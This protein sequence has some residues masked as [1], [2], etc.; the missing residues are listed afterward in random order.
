MQKC[1]LNENAVNVLADA[2]Q[3]PKCSLEILRFHEVKIS[4]VDFSTFAA[5]IAKNKSISTLSLC[6]WDYGRFSCLS[7]YCN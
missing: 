5:A 1:T 3:S 7:S 6:D 4:P 2:M